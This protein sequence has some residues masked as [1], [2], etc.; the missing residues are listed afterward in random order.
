MRDNL[1][2]R[3][4][5]GGAHHAHED[6]AHLVRSRAPCHDASHGERFYELRV[7]LGVQ[8]LRLDVRAIVIG[9]NLE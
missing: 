4:A 6:H 9:A 8:V 2:G 1:L 3:R 5:V 7:P